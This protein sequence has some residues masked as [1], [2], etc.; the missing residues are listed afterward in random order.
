MSVY[1]CDL[2]MD[3]MPLV[4]DGVVSEATRRALEEHLEHCENCRALFAQLPDTN[5]RESEA[6]RTLSRIRRMWF[7]STLLVMILGIVVSICITSFRGMTVLNFVLMPLV[8]IAAYVA[9]RWRGWMVPGG[10]F[11]VSFF[12][13]LGRYVLID[14]NALNAVWEN[15]LLLAGYYGFL[16]AFGVMAA[17]LCHYVFAHLDERNHWERLKKRLGRILLAIFYVV[18]VVGSTGIIQIFVGNP[19]VKATAEGDAAHYVQTR[20]RNHEFTVGEAEYNMKR[21]GYSVWVYSTSSRDT[22][23]EIG[24]N[25]LGIR[26]W[27]SYDDYVVTGMTTYWRLGDS[28]NTAVADTL[29]GSPFVF[30]DY[31]TRLFSYPPEDW[32]DELEFDREYSR[33]ELNLWAEKTGTIGVS[34]DPVVHGVKNAAE[35]LLEVRRMM[36]A[37]GLRFSVLNLQIQYESGHKYYTVPYGDITEENLAQNMNR[38]QY[39]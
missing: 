34:Y 8:G 9:L 37:A 29:A 19:L 13:M 28:Y 32:L 6:E 31:Q 38:Y 1:D 2:Y 15:S 23:F 39:P 4:R 25:S 3:L 16:C 22:Y 7:W 12:G 27:D 10:V 33:E 14:G 11:M 5:P 18:F 24:Y 36:D 21:A 20:Y 30:V 17:H 35:L 26:A